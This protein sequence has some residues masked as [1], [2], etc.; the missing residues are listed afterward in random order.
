MPTARPSN[1][2]LAALPAK[3]YKALF[4]KLERVALV[5][6]DHLFEPGDVIT[7]VQFPESGIVSLLSK[8]D[9]NSFIEVGL[10]GSEGMVG[11]PLF[12]GVE[13]T[14]TRALVQGAGFAG[15]MS[16]KDFKYSCRDGNQ[17]PGILLSWI[18]SQMTQ[19]SQSVGCNRFHSI[20]SRLARW[21]LMTGDRMESDEFLV[22]QESLSNMLGVRRE[23][24]NKA[25]GDLQ[26]RELILYIRGNMNI[27][28]RKRLV[29]TACTC[30][31]R[32]SRA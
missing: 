19:I 2:L 8:V 18:H 27:L 5:Y 24:V 29:R 7:E 30:Y 12:L 9:D 3:E 25:A 14:A 13:E 11:L 32:P 23:A 15:V 17:L 6:N 31:K 16:A 26:A 28:D 10:V 4:P 21:L 22:T 1:S 20:G